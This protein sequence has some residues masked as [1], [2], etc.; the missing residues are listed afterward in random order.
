ME[1]N[2]VAAATGVSSYLIECL[3]W[4]V[5]NANF[6]HATYFA[7]LREVLAHSFNNTLTDDACKGWGEINELKYLFGPHQS[8]SRMQ[9][10]SF[11]SAAWDYVGFD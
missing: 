5:P 8:W 3:V 2:G 6:S 4:N 9:A 7:E 1:D 11:L 10:H